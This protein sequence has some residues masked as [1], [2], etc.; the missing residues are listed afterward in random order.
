MD[1]GGVG[2]LHVA[3]ASHRPVFLSGFFDSLSGV[4]GGRRVVG[5]VGS[6][7]EISA[8]RGLGRPSIGNWLQTPDWNFLAFSAK[9]RHSVKAFLADLARFGGE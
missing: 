5:S 4:V 1:V 9:S 3:G 7:L 2:H 8:D 6:G